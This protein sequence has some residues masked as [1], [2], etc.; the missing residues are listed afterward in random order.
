MVTRQKNS[1]RPTWSALKRQLVG[2]E[3]KELLSLI[4]DLYGVSKDNQTFLHAR[5]ALL[6]DVLDPYKKIISRWVCP[7]VMRNQDYS[8]AKAKKAISEYRRAVGKPAG[9]AELSVFYCEAC[10]DFLD[11]CGTDDDGYFDSWVR[12]YEQALKAIC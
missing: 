11:S 1:N 10:A 4:R 3:Q 2:L 5:F 8:V 12:M 7:D 6:D 9:V